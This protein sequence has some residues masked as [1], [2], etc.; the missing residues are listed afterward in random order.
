MTCGRAYVG[1]ISAFVV[2][3]YKRSFVTHT[4]NPIMLG[5]NKVATKV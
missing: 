2:G 4:G 3:L 1:Q 5:K